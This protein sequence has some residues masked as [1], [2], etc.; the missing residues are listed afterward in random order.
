M[1]F[2]SCILFIYAPYPYISQ[3]GRM[4]GHV[5]LYI[6]HGGRWVREPL[7]DYVGG[8]VHIL[9]DFDIES[10]DILTILN[11]YKQQFNN[12]NLQH[13][14]VLEPNMGMSD[15]GLYLV[16]DNNR[17]RNILRKINVDT[18]VL[19]FYDNHEVVA[20]IL[21]SYIN[22]RE[23]LDKVSPSSKDTLDALPGFE[24]QT[25]FLNTRNSRVGED[26]NLD[27]SNSEGNEKGEKGN[28]TDSDDDSD[29]SE[30]TKEVANNIEIPQ[31]I[32]HPVKF[33][34][35]Y[36]RP[37]FLLGITFSYVDYVRDSIAK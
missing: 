28:D 37:Y 3:N 24:G 9:E 12:A 34:V 19:E 8:R 6:H 2:I 10:F 4:D 35:D 21:T 30:E 11:V 22:L 17:I 23:N 25:R 32:S 16:D 31:K 7:L 20:P 15:G 13:L 36:Q 33:N 26:I 14:Y 29:V 18:Y 27:T 5:D 1:F